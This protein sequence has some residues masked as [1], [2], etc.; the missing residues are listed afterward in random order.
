MLNRNAVVSAV[1]L[2][3]AILT[4]ASSAQ[5]AGAARILV[6]GPESRV[7]EFHQNLKA[8]MAAY[9]V[10]SDFGTAGVAC[11]FDSGRKNCD[12]L[13]NDKDGPVTAEYLTFSEHEYLTAFLVSWRKLQEREPSSSISISFGLDSTAHDCSTATQPCVSASMCLAQN[14]RRCDEVKGPPCTSCN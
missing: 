8:T 11:S 1:S 7:H 9:L 3:L 12:T 2:G 4:S 6:E 10:D 13:D 14:P 5:D